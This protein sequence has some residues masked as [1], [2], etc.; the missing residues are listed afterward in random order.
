VQLSPDL[1]RFEQTRRRVCSLATPSGRITLSDLT[2]IET[3]RGERAERALSGE[4]EYR[5]VLRQR[6][7]VDL[8]RV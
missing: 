6:F 4:Q 7:G 1:A 3:E 2:L 8:G 5:D